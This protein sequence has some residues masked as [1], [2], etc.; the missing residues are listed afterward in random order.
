MRLASRGHAFR[1]R[2]GKAWTQRGWTRSC[3]SRKECVKPA[4][5]HADLYRSTTT[6]A[7]LRF[8]DALQISEGAR[9][10]MKELCYRN[11]PVKTGTPR[12]L[13]QF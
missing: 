8:E 13:E 12:A 6:L 11:S 3:E 2:E 4:N 7:E 1:R 9:T 5:Q 10:K